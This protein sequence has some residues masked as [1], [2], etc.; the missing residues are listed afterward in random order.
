[1]ERSTA[2]PSR[3]SAVSI[4]STAELSPSGPRLH[5][6]FSDAAPALARPRTVSVARGPTAPAIV[7][8]AAAAL[9]AG[10]GAGAGFAGGRRGALRTG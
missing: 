1:M 9:V 6:P 10:A 5:H 7:A 4:G 8:I 2:R 3:R